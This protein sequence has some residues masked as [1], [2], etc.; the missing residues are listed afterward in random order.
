MCRVWDARTCSQVFA[1]KGGHSKPIR[2]VTDCLSGQI[3]TGSDDNTIRIWFYKAANKQKKLKERFEVNLK[4]TGHT[5]AV[6]GLEKFAED[7]YSCSYDK[8]LRWWQMTMTR[9]A[10]QSG[11]TEIEEDVYI[12]SCKKVYCSES[13]AG[14]T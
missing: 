11:V 12:V 3:A 1:L 5:G 6:L 8:T 4:L 14:F 13:T 10:P 7:L 2:S 9:K